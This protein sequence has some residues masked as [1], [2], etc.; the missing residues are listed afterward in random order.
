MSRGS[1]PVKLNPLAI[2]KREHPTRP[3]VEQLLAAE[4]TAKLFELMGPIDREL[5]ST[6]IGRFPVAEKML[7]ANYYIPYG[8][9]V[10]ILTFMAPPGDFL[11]LESD[12]KKVFFDLEFNV[13]VRPVGY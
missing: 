4:R 11:F 13:P 5:Y 9:D 10:Y 1:L 12:V 3:Y 6:E 2:K 7:V 8:D